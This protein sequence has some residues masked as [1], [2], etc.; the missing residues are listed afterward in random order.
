MPILAVRVMGGRTGGS[1]RTA[2]ELLSTLPDMTILFFEDPRPER[3]VTA[4][5]G[6]GRYA[7][8]AG[9][10]AAHP[11]DA[12]GVD[13]R[14]FWL[15]VDGERLAALCTRTFEGPS[16][17]AVRVRPIGESVALVFA[18][19][20]MLAPRGRPGETE[21][22][23]GFWIPVRVDAGEGERLA[24]FIPHLVVD[25][26]NALVIGRES[27]GFPK[28]L[29]AVQIPVDR[30]AGGYDVDASASGGGGLFT[31][32]RIGRIGSRRAAVAVG[33]G[34]VGPKWNARAAAL[35]ADNL[36]LRGDV[37]V[38][39]LRQ[40][41]AADEP[42]RAVFQ[43]ILL[44]HN[45]IRRLD[46][47]AV[48]PHAFTFV[49]RDGF[50]ATE[51]GLRGE[52]PVTGANFARLDFTLER[53]TPLWRRVAAP[54]SR[55]VGTFTKR[56]VLVLGGGM[57][58]LSA[59]FALTSS[60][61]ARERYD[62]TVLETGFRLGGKCAS[63]RNP[64]HADRIEEHGLHVWFGCYEEAFRMMRAVYAERGAAGP[65][66]TWRDAFEPH[67]SIELWERRPDGWDPWRLEFPENELVPGEG[68]PWRDTASLLGALARWVRTAIDMA[69]LPPEERNGVV[70][71]ASV[72]ASNATRAG[73]VLVA[74]IVS[75]AAD[76]I[77]RGA[78]GER[79]AAV[80]RGLRARLARAAEGVLEAEASWRRMWIQLDLA[81]TALA[82][83]AADRL[84]DRGFAAIDDEDFRAWLRR[85]GASATSLRSAP[86]RVLYDLA[87]AYEGGDR[88]RPAFS[89]GVLLEA[90]LRMLFGYA[91]AFQWKMRAGM[92][93]VVFTP[94]YDVLRGRGVRFEFFHR[95]DRLRVAGGQ[96]QAVEV[97][98]Q[99]TVIGAEYDPLVEVDGLR[100]WPDRP[101]WDQLEEGSELRA[102]GADLASPTEN[103]IGDEV[104]FELGRD[105]DEVV[106]GIPVGALRGIAAD[107][108][109]VDPR[110]RTM[111]E[112]LGTVATASAQLWLD[113][114]LGRAASIRGGLPAPFDT[115]ADMRHVLDREGWQRAEG[116]RPRDL[117]YGCGP[118][119]DMD[120]SALRARLG[121]YLTDHGAAIWPALDASGFD[122]ERLVDPEERSG[123][124]RLAAQVVRVN[125]EGSER[126]VQSLPG[127]GRLRMTPDG[128]GFDN[129]W[130]VGDWTRTGFDVGC[131]EAAARS[132]AL[133]AEAL[134]RR[135]ATTWSVSEHPA[136]AAE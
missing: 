110:W 32:E 29:G 112:G 43:E 128:S 60:A 122:W 106:L 104:R 11:F 55:R 125:V 120:V 2:R 3:E 10:V 69:L 53:A 126:Y 116:V 94:L 18:H 79:A 58:A 39:L 56:R 13:L 107:L 74:Q 52:H 15:K 111:L 72:L 36:L 33:H 98:R 61:E 100:C 8:H 115:W 7:D 47:V 19:I 75:R 67:G 24:W 92:G 42:E 134:E 45:R 23:A 87:F 26:A 16:G 12:S 76:R 95:V 50:A 117:V 44:V 17:G 5:S 14:A 131:I 135:A 59:V 38:L 51:L 66:P 35:H 4:T 30:D 64:D 25:S 93:D 46:G 48:S 114:P 28:V 62:V 90:V 21:R 86:L 103:G 34:L 27:F 83:I 99:A 37:P 71:G 109:A 68:G 82:G 124:A 77:A 133:C 57:A 123:S 121:D 136:L 81:L 132:G 49:G 73:L 119:P 105:F 70:S 127:T 20:G 31:V 97:T 88:S 9:A 101:R 129:L 41:R 40:L 1:L 130:L 108:A 6:S 113:M 96:V 54:V 65:I 118:I 78:G 80:V 89:A 85:H 63:G 91:G 102:R 22:E 84:V